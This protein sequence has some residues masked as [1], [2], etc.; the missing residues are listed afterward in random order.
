MTEKTDATKL[1]KNGIMR[2]IKPG[3]W[4]ENGIR[5]LLHPADFFQ[6]MPAGGGYSGPVSQVLFYSLV[7][8]IVNILYLFSLGY[9]GTVLSVLFI[10]GFFGSLVLFFARLPWLSALS[11]PVPR[12]DFPLIPMGMAIPLFIPLISVAAVALFFHP[13]LRIAGGKGGLQETFKVVALAYPVVGLFQILYLVTSVVYLLYRSYFNPPMSTI[14][15]Y[16][17]LLLF[18][19]TSA[20]YTYI[21]YLGFKK[22]HGLGTLRLALIVGVPFVLQPILFLLAFVFAFIGCGNFLAGNI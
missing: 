12:W 7:I 3:E 17:A 20:Y 6:K 9:T 16:D 4:I 15:D 1:E 5:V 22:V 21:L 18:F 19:L 14:L 10:G 8:A 2:F 13:M 11:G